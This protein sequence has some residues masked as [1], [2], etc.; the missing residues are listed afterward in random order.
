MFLMRALFGMYGIVA[1]QPAADFLTMCIALLLFRKLQW[2][3]RAEQE[4]DGTP[5]RT[6]E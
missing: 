5:G 3:L 4:L 6:E 1:A 2:R